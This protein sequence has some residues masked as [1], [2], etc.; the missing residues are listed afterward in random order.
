MRRSWLLLLL[1]LFVCS[2]ISRSDDFSF[3]FEGDARLRERLILLQ[4]TT[5][6]PPIELSKWI[7][8]EPLSFADLKGKIV[9][10]DFWATWCG[11]CVGGIPYHNA[12]A[13]K[14]AEHVVL[15]G[16]CHERGSESMERV[17]EKHDIRY[18]IGI[19][20]RNRM[21]QAYAVNGYPDYYV[22]DQEGKLVVADCAH[23]QL[24]AVIQ[25]LIGDS[26]ADE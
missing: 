22:I 19:D 15:I 8:S 20:K 9:V 1:A 7:N 12:I 14:Y 13:E 11:P 6:P 17:A 18:P 10:L 4:G 5:A 23:T 24:E 2:S 16:V 21:I 26:A 25:K 3:A